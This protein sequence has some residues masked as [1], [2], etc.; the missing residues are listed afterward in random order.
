MKVS[1]NYKLLLVIAYAG[2]LLF[3]I[4]LNIFGG[5]RQGLSNLIVNGAMFVITGWILL[6]CEKKSFNP[7]E[8]IEEELKKVTEKIKLDAMHERR[9][10]WEKYKEEKEELFTNPVLKEQYYDY[11]YELDRID[12]SDNTLYKCDIE[13]YINYDLIDTV[14]H[15]NLLNQV[16]G[17]MTGLGIL[18]TFI[19]L[20]LGLQSFNTGTTAEIANSIEPLMDGIKVAFQTSIY[21]MVLSLMFNYVYKRELEDAESAVRGFVVAHKKH[22]MPDTSMDGYNKLVQLQMQQAR[23]TKDISDT[24]SYYTS[25]GLE[26]TLKPRFDGFDATIS[27]FAN[28][29]TKNQLDALSSVVQAFLKE[30]DKE[31]NSSFQRLSDTVDST[32]VLQNENKEQME[33]LCTRSAELAENVNEIT[34]QTGRTAS[35]LG[36]YANDVRELKTAMD[37]DLERTFK[38]LE[39]QLGVQAALLSQLQNTLQTMPQSVGDTMRMINDSLQYTQDQLSDTIEKVRDTVEHIPEAVD[40]SY[41][42]LE[43]SFRKADM[44]VEKLSNSVESLD[45]HF[46]RK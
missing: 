23:S 11:Q 28:L 21:G 29:A 41:L 10:L 12:N 7:T 14:I 34:R 46:F 20:S 45:R 18:G 37:S 42:G 5:Q 8:K 2:L 13:E 35:A 43:R 32:M 31:L 16:P 9:F 15:R 19:G 26:K 44:A 22:V 6:S 38:M 40:Y 17:A 1:K 25:E 24:L 3:F 30:M 4:G 33:K 36:T 39:D 27:D